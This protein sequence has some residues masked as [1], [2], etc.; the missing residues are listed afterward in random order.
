MPFDNTPQR[1]TPKPSLAELA[2]LLR[3]REEWPAGFHW[4]YRFSFSCAGGL[5]ELAWKD[6]GWYSVRLPAEVYSGVR[7]PRGLLL[8]FSRAARMKAVQPEHVADA[9]DAYLARSQSKRTF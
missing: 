3:C 2:R 6:A 1:T 7:P 8:F 9:I 4:D 5:A